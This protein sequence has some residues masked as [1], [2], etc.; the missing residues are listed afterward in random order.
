MEHR[1]GERKEGEGGSEGRSRKFLEKRSKKKKIGFKIFFLD[2]DSFCLL[3]DESRLDHAADR[4]KA[5]Q[6]PATLRK[7]PTSVT[8]GSLPPKKRQ[9]QSPPSGSQT[10]LSR[11]SAQPPPPAAAP[12]SPTPAPA[13]PAPVL[14]A[15]AARRAARLASSA[16]SSSAPQPRENVQVKSPSPPPPQPRD[17]SDSSDSASDVEAALLN[18]TQPGKGKGKGKKKDAVKRKKE[19]PSRYFSGAQEDDATTEQAAQDN[20]GTMDERSSR[21]VARRAVRPRRRREKT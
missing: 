17:E 9:R 16:S 2:V 6:M 1:K 11:G 7:A 10:S 15:V 8:G 12:S 21:P 19:T 14:S 20:E 18:R 13:A 3:L 4:Y 5:A